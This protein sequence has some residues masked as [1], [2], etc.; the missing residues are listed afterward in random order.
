MLDSSLRAGD[1]VATTN[2]LV[3]YSGVRIGNAKSA[4]FTPIAAYPGLT[5]DVRARLGEMKVA[6]VSAEMIASDLPPSDATVNVAPV[7][8]PP[9][10]ALLRDKR[11]EAD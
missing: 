9:R 8:A 2:G 5:A 4:E 6:P 3:V 1:V 11:A 10:A 7:L